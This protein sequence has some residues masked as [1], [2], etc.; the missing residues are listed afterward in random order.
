MYPAGTLTRPNQW[1][2]RVMPRVALTDRFVTHAKPKSGPRTDYFDEHT[3]GLALRV[4]DA[5]TKAWTF[6]FTS[7]K[8][9]KRARLTFGTCPGRSLSAARARAGEAKSHLD[10]QRDPRDVFAA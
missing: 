10:E 4:S 6:H 2:N 8:D 1:R 9:G 3:P 5:G 7:P